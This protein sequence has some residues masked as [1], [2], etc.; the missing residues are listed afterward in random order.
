MNEKLF[1]L[2]M[3]I[4]KYLPQKLKQ[5]IFDYLLKRSIKKGFPLMP[6]VEPLSFADCKSPFQPHLDELEKQM[7]ISKEASK[8]MVS[9]SEIEKGLEILKDLLDKPMKH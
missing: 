3:A 4:E 5:K 8:L 9:D 6:K 2:L 1:K 7:A